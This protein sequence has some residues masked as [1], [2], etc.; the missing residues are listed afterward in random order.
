M[1]MNG[2]SALPKAT[3]LLEPPH[4]IVLCL[5][6]DTHW[7]EVTPLQ[8]CKQCILQPQP[9]ILFTNPSTRAGYDTRSIFKRSLTGLNSELS[10][11]QTSCLTKA[12]EPSLSPAI[13]AI[14]VWRVLLLCRDAVDVLNSP[15]RLG[16][17]RWGSL[18]PLQRC[19]Q[20]ILQSQPIGPVQIWSI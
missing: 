11:F 9:S 7:K 12:E 4:Q 8:R 2:Y 3:A 5:I 16:H 15:S 20:C 10:F 17:T 6:L 19:G 1:A 18:A 14:L 13:Q